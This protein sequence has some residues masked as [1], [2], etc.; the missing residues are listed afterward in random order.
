VHAP[1]CCLRLGGIP[2]QSPVRLWGGG[3]ARYGVP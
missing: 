2:D 1:S 3:A